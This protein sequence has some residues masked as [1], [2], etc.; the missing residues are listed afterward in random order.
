[1]FK[2]C[3][4]V[5]RVSKSRFGRGK[6]YGM[7]KFGDMLAWTGA[8]AVVVVIFRSLYLMYHFRDH[9]ERSNLRQVC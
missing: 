8:F 4:Q 9:T 1:M 2:Q 5:F 3:Y 7:G 6:R